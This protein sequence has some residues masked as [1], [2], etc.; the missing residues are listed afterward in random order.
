M[1]VITQTSEPAASTTLTNSIFTSPQD[2]TLFDILSDAN[3]GTQVIGKLLANSTSTSAEKELMLET[4]RRVLL[5]INTSSTPPYRVLLEAVGLPVPPSSSPSPVARRH[6]TQQWQGQGQGQ[7]YQPQYQYGGFSQNQYHH[8][9]QHQQQY[10]PQYGQGQGMNLSPLLVP[11]NMP[12]GQMRHR[13]HDPNDP[14]VTPM[15]GHAGPRTPVPHPHQGRG[16]GMMSPTSDP[17]NPVRSHF[18]S[19][20]LIDGEKKRRQRLMI[21]RITI[22]R[23]TIYPPPTP[24][25]RRSGSTS[26]FPIRSISNYIRTT[27]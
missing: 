22:Y 6:Q 18:V 13:E 7:G 19:P 14:N 8:Q 3:N 12:L 10:M 17:F 23:F 11:Q 21:V 9:H 16:Q 20:T 5:T 2:Q 1:I 26:H 25:S 27:T 15:P 4:V 24:T